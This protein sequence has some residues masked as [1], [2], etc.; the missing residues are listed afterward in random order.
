[1]AL[2]LESVL[3]D[4][5]NFIFENAMIVFLTE[6]I[7]ILESILFVRPEVSPV[8]WNIFKVAIESFETYAYEYFDSFQPFLKVSLTKDLGNLILL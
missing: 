3:K 4:L 5:I 7:E 8:I 2:Q 6:V 1:M